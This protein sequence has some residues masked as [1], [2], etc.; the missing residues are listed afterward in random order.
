MAKIFPGFLI[1]SYVAPLARRKSPPSQDQ[2]EGKMKLRTELLATGTNTTGIELTPAQVEELGGG[3]RPAVN[4]RV[5]GFAYRTSV[6]SMGGR[7]LIPVSAERRAAAGVKAGDTIEVELALDTAPR[8]LAVPADLAATLG[9]EASA[10]AAFDKLSYSAR[11]RHV[12][13]VEGAKSAETRARRIAK[14]VDELRNA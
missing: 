5:N 10:R 12:L 13:A 8:E 9:A 14:I 1:A 7:F 11:Q 3:Q 6:G 4:V 2:R